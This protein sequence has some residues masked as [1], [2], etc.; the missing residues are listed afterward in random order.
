[1]NKR[2]IILL[3]AIVVLAAGLILIKEKN[4]QESGV[5]FKDNCFRVELALTAEERESGLMF[6]ES[7]APDNGMLFIFQEEGEYPFWMKDT[8]I[9]LDIIWLDKDGKVVFMAKNMEPCQT[10]LCLPI[11]PDKKAKYVLEVNGGVA[12]KI[13]LDIGSLGALLILQE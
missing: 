2:I 6:R 7:L 12:D 1:M 4:K 13:G 9:P 11:D 8:L 10:N 3:A 5:C